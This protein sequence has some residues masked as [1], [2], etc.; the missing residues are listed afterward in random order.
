MRVYVSVVEILL[1]IS[2]S[3]SLLSCSWAARSSTQI[4]IILVLLLV[5]WI[6]TLLPLHRV[7]TTP[8]VGVQSYSSMP[9]ATKNRIVVAHH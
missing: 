6:H 1:A 4:V 9:I 8:Q 2:G 3:L 7:T 5:C